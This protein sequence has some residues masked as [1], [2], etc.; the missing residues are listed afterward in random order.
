[1][2][3]GISQF[4]ITDHLA[5]GLHSALPS[6]VVITTSTKP[7]SP[8]SITFWIALNRRAATSHQSD[9]ALLSRPKARLTALRLTPRIRSIS[10]A[11]IIWRSDISINVLTTPEIAIAAVRSLRSQRKMQRV[12][13]LRILLDRLELRKRPDKQ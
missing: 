2:V 3:R 7:G 9:W 4:A 1:M 12:S 11:V 5:P 8:T 6:V 10:L 13:R